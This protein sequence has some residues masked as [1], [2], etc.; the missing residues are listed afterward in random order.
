MLAL[1]ALSAGA[2]SSA[3]IS[4]TPRVRLIRA[5]AVGDA[6]DIA[7]DAS[8]RFIAKTRF[9]KLTVWDWMAG[10]AVDPRLPWPQNIEAVVVFCPTKPIFVVGTRDGHVSVREVGTWGERWAVQLKRAQMREGVLTD[11]AVTRDGSR[12]IAATD[13]GRVRVWDSKTGQ[14]IRGFVAKPA[15]QGRAI[16]WRAD[17]PR[18][19]A[20]HSIAVDPRGEWLVTSGSGIPDWKVRVWDLD[21]GLEIAAFF[22]AWTEELPPGVSV[23]VGPNREVYRTW[24]STVSVSKVTDRGR[25]PFTPILGDEAR[26]AFAIDPLGRYVVTGHDGGVIAIREADTYVVVE[27][28][29]VQSERWPKLAWA[30]SGELIASCSDKGIINVW[31]IER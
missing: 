24:F 26:Y 16:P 14:L 31:R 1:M 19:T 3:R 9:G 17:G 23:D 15:E 21:T 20:L 30:P 5:L 27:M 22:P 8:G 13:D 25:G 11:V 2:C 10:R 7:F 12:V 28:L 4:G 18:L 29:R 6:G